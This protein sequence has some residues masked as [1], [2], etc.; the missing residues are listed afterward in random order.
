MYPAK[1]QLFQCASP[2][3]TGGT[4]QDTARQMAIRLSMGFYGITWELMAV[5]GF[6]LFFDGKSKENQSLE[7]ITSRVFYKIM[8]L[9]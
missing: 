7:F 9:L 5:N 4:W 3:I 6:G 8:K 1:N 2:K